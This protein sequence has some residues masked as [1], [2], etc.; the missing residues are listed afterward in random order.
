MFTKP[1][2]YLCSALSLASALMLPHVVMA[3]DAA[4]QETLKQET[5]WTLSVGAAALVTPAYQGSDNYTLMTVPDLR[6]K[7]QDRF[8]ASVNQGVGYNVVTRASG[9]DGWKIGP[10][11]KLDFGRDEDGQGP[12]IVAGDTDDLQGMGEINEA[13]ELGGFVD[14]QWQFLQTRLEVRQA[15][16]GYDGLIA[17]FGV[18]YLSRIGDD[19]YFSVGPR[20]TWA[21]KDY[22]QT[23]FGVDATQ[24]ANTGLAQY[25]AGSGITS[26]GLGAFVYKPLNDKV[27]FTTFAS[28]DR[29]GDE[30]ADSSFTKV[31]GTANQFTVGMGVSYAFDF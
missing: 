24:S 17:D 23:Y 9:E 8:F 1:N 15:I 18:N 12:F 19:G 14:Y 21:S 11:A 26:Y 29:L 16:G 13:V 4:E 5:H 2:L 10:V 27:S 3:Q 30:A 31:R 20:L 25:N 22:N 6:L 28:Y 7:Y